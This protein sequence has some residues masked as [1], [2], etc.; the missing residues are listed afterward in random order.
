[1]GYKYIKDEKV[2]GKT[3]VLRAGID[4][5]VEEN[6]LFEGT[7]LEKQAQSIKQLSEKGA[8]LVVLGHQ[9]RRGQENF[10]SLKQHAKAI[11]E[12]IEKEVKLLPWDSDYVS[13]IKAMENG[14]IILMENVRFNENE[15]QSFAPEEASKIE[16]VQKIASV[17]DMFV[18]NAFSVCHRP[19]PSVVGFAKLLP[20]FVGPLL[21]AELKAI[22]KVDSGLKPAVY[23]LGGSKLSDSLSLMQNLFEKGKADKTCV[24][25]LLGELFIKASG[26]QLGNKDKFFEE[27]NLNQFIEQA[28]SILSQHPD[29]IVMPVD[30]AIM[31]DYDEREEVMVEELPKE[32]MVYDIGMETVAEFKG[33]FKKAKLIVMNGPMGVFEKMDFETGTKKVLNAVSKNR[34]FSLVGGGDTELALH[35]ADFSETD[36]SHVSLGGKVLL[37]ALLGKELP[38]LTALQ[39]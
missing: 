34:A 24:G 26:K 22:E 13:E 12:R 36:F 2:E 27:K 30:V 17:S 33:S 8:K 16:W 6:E 5:N 21:E 29:K 19:Q 32:N 3:L 9:G 20:S 35:Q 37:E 23:V 25:G 11:E 1:M 7:R 31:N 28:K 4:S 18:Q 10:I 39:K 38:G 14:S 15:E